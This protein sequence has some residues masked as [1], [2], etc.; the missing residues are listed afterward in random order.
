[1]RNESIVKGLNVNLILTSTFD[2][3][4]VQQNPL[5]F[6]TELSFAF[7][8][9]EDSTRHLNTL[10]MSVAPVTE[11]PKRARGKL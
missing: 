8:E 4:D 9:L 2:R 1:M 3:C 7:A 11:F 6:A 10:P 5:I